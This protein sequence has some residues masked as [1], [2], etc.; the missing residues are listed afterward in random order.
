MTRAKQ[1]PSAA[2]SAPGASRRIQRQ[3]EE[4]HMRPLQWPIVKRMLGYV[5]PYKYSYW[6]GMLC[7]A[8]THLLG[9][10]PAYLVRHGV[11]RNILGDAFAETGE[12]LADLNGLIVTG[13]LLVGV[14]VAN[15]LSHA[16]QDR[17]SVV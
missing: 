8:V 10:A 2:A 11:D 3:L 14:A 13:L 16:G 1:P 17:K 9:L 4:A 15:Y 5:G 12:M 6:F 7:I